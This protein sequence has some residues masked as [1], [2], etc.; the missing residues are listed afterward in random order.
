MII[1]DGDEVE[2]KCNITSGAL[3]SSF[4][5]KVTWLYADHDSSTM[6]TPLVE[7]DHTGLL[8][9]PKNQGI[10]G[11]QGRLRPS[12]PVQNSFY[13]GIQRA[14]EEDSGIY[15][16]QVEQYQLDHQSQWQQK[17]SDLGGSIRLSVNVTGMITLFRAFSCRIQL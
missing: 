11:L 1:K 16:C 13:L 15:Q 3:S 8:R 17:A 14:N 7:L 5:Y 10:G 6:M 2:F 12:R 4:F 9:Y